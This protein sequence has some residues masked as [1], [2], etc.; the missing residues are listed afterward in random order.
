MEV[1]LGK[2]REAQFP[3]GEALNPGGILPSLIFFRSDF[4]EGGG[5]GFST[6]GM[7]IQSMVGIDFYRVIEEKHSC[8]VHD[9]LGQESITNANH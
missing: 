6:A 9:A 2:G 4:E 3:R 7:L 1:K 8:F 5:G